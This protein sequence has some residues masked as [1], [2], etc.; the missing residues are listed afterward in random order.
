MI[1]N[2]GTHTTIVTAVGEMIKTCPI[3]ISLKL[4][5]DTLYYSCMTCQTVVCISIK[6][7]VKIT[8][9]NCGL[10]LNRNDK[11]K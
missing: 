11:N 10:S 8:I 6:D 4:S 3:N 1:L 2:A 5:I 9:V 7:L